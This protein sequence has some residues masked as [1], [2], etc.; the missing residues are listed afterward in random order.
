MTMVET[1]DGV[2][3]SVRGDLV[4]SLWK[5]PARVHRTRW[6]FDIVDEAAAKNPEG[7]GVLLLILPTSSPPDAPARAEN[8]VRLRKLG[9]VIQRVVTVPLGDA[10]FLNVV[11]TVM[12]AMFIVQGQARVQ[13][14]ESS[15][16]SGIGR[17]LEE[18]SHRTP[19]RAQVER[20]VLALYEALGVI[21]PVD[22]SSPKAERRIS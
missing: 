20:D 5:E 11:R 16:S 1:N 19:G 8:A 6:F 7:V 4:L 13:I 17:T 18:A 12:R 15:V 9:K 3:V 10:L 21:P 14:V 22:L 2:A